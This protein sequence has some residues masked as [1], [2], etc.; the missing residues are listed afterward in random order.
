MTKETIRL[1]VA[2]D[3]D[4]NE[5]VEK[6]AQKMGVSKAGMIRFM[7]Y[8]FFKQQDAMDSLKQV[9]FLKELMNQPK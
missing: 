8:D 5:K 1:N 9:E 3:L 7:I 4:T 2:I 6:Q